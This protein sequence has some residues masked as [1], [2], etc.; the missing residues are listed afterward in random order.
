MSQRTLIAA[1]AGVALIV[2]AGLAVFIGGESFG[3]FAG[4]S[5][6]RRSNVTAAG[7][8]DP[9]QD[10]AGETPFDGKDEH[11][12]YINGPDGQRIYIDEF[13]RRYIIG[14]GGERIFVDEFGRPTGV[15]EFGRPIGGDSAPADKPGESGRGNGNGDPASTE[16]ELPDKEA[17][18]AELGGKVVDDHGNPY[19]GA[20]VTALVVG[21]ES[22]S[23]A[24]NDEGAF[25]FAALPSGKPLVLSA[26]NDYGD[27][28]K[29]VNT[30]LAPG[31]T[32]LKAPLVLPR[33]T[34][35]RGVV[36]NAETGT[37][38][39]GVQVTLSGATNEFGNRFTTQ[40]AQQTDAGGAFAFEK[41]TPAGYRLQVSMS[42]FAPRILN[43][44]EPPSTL[45]V[46]LSPGA[47]ITGTVSDQGGNPIPGAKVS[48]D[49]RAEPAQHFHTDTTT[50]AAGFY[51]VKCQPE[52]QHNTVSVI[53]PGFKSASRTL[54]RSGAEDVNF[55][56]A[57]SGNVVLTGRLLS[58]SGLPVQTAT[59]RGYDDAGKY[60][61]IV[62]SIGPDAEG[63]FRCEAVV[64]AV[65]L[66][67][68][69]PGLAEARADY[70]PV[71]GGEVALGDV[72]LDDGYAVFGVVHEDGEIDSPIAGAEVSVGAAKVTTGA[73]GRYRIEGLGVEEFIVRTLHPAYLGNAN[74]VTPVPGQYENELNV[75]LRKAGF[76]ARV[77]VR[78][79][80]GEPI[81]GAKIIVVAYGQTV[82]TGA[83]GLAHIEPLSSM[84]VDVRVEKAGYAAVETRI[85]SDLPQKTAEKPPQEIFLTPGAAISGV[86]T[87]EG[88]PLP[89]A[90]KVE[91]WNEQDLVATVYTDTEGKYQT[92][93]LPLGQYYVGLP[94]YIHAAQPVALTDEGAEFDIELGR[95]CHLKGKLLRSNGQPHANAGVYIYRR[96][97]VYWTA[98]IHTGPEG[99]YEVM[100]L[101][102][103]TWVFCALKTQG[104]TA[105]QF[106]VDVDVSEPGWTTRNV[107]LPQIT[108]VMKWRVTY[109][110]DK[111]VRRARVAVTNLDADFPRAL[112]AAYV[113]TDD[114]GYYTAERLENGARMMARVGGYQDDAATGT[115]FSEEVIVPAD[116]TPVSANIVVPREGVRLRV[117][118]RRADGGP[119]G[120]GPLTYM[121][122]AQGRLS[123][124]YFGGGGFNGHTDIYDVV[125]GTYTIVVTIRGLKVAQ[126]QVTV[127]TQNI[128]SGLEIQLEPDDRNGG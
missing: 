11:G 118:L 46:E 113:V 82:T 3:L 84:S 81:E 112:L 83:D 75:P 78:E 57:P 6:E 44:V 14:P 69:S 58:K 24:T 89:G 39:S 12:P 103:G 32:T 72:Y 99:N 104:D 92:D 100:N 60:R 9:F 120:G 98:T 25:R 115:A 2:F 10:P 22:T 18:P 128:L 1:L 76:D 108:G 48:C 77:L 45:I 53:A 52:S 63:N 50:D 110:D 66:R 62:Q 109:P 88:E 20:R 27:S 124:L 125:P 7:T 16:E 5:T 43:N 121:Y 116:D 30:R 28:S 35:I 123:G 31:A 105:A 56:L 21:G 47:V 8:D 102:P 36:R 61:A 19:A 87:S 68:Q 74:R 17:A 41:L 51:A 80:T 114:D 101:F 86:C 91:V 73:D 119:L 26:H 42:G 95:V 40:A 107:Q 94:E 33:D 90:A 4:D 97:N 15:D 54:V 38:L 111:P 13:G 71:P 122:D 126:T 67:I 117:N 37:P 70:A 23:V 79:E 65:Q 93:A 127:G 29:P 55:K 96:D 59:F 64:E 85:T 49:F 34:A 106:A